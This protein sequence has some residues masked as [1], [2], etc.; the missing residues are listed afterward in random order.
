MTKA[1]I[2]NNNEAELREGGGSKKTV[3]GYLV[4]V[5]SVCKCDVFPS[6]YGHFNDK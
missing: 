5:P 1:R 2:K 3:V 4:S 6:I